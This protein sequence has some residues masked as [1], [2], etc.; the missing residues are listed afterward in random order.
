MV[1]RSPFAKPSAQII[2]GPFGAPLIEARNLSYESRGTMLLHG[3]AF[4]I[5]RGRRTVILGPNG[6]GKSILLRLMHGLLKPSYG[7]VLFDGQPRTTQ[8]TIPQAMVFQKPVLLRRSVARNLKFAARLT[9]SARQEQEALVERALHDARLTHLAARPARSLSGGEQQRLA[10]ARA[11]L[12]R[13][14]LLFLDEPTSNLDPASVNA[15]ERQILAASETG[16]SVVMV[17]HDLGQARRLGEDVLFL[18]GGELVESGPAD[19]VLHTPQTAAVQAWIDGELFLGG[20][21]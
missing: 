2:H 14:E 17:T 9:A 10:I 6:S 21:R 7:E 1:K 5:R 4:T 19:Q 8:T 13:P 15:V 12:S 20:P 11:L 3:L 18:Q 16:I